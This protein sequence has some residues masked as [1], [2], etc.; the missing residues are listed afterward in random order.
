MWIVS[1]LSGGASVLGLFLIKAKGL[2]AGGLGYLWREVRRRCRKWNVAETLERI[3]LKE[4]ID[5]AQKGPS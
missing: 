1:H 3:G 4:T 2:R 5:D